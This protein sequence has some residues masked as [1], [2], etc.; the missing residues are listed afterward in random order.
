MNLFLIP[1]I[2]RIAGEVKDAI[3]TGT[4]FKDVLDKIDSPEM[5]DMFESLGEQMFPAIAP[6][7]RGVAAIVSTYSPDHTKWV[8]G[9]LNKMLVPSPGLVVDGL[10]GP[11]TR[12]A[13]EQLQTNLGI[14]VDGWVGD[15]TSALIQAFLAK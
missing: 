4:S 5:I 10:Y 13:V 14:T 7:L 11:A 2:L 1:D 12:K 8:Q 3:A 15:K 6:A 9:S